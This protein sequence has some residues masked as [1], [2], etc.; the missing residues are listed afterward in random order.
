MEENGQQALW[1]AIADVAHYV[2]AGNGAR[3]FGRRPSDFGL[4]ASHRVS[5]MLPPKL[6]DD[7]CS[8][9]GRC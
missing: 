7:L 5:P 8:L 2:Q 1:V 6:A 4:F 3:P 9:R